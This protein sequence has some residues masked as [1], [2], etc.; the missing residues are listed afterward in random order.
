[1]QALDDPSLGGKAALVL[2]DDAA[3]PD[4]APPVSVTERLAFACDLSASREWR[5]VVLD[6]AKGT[7]ASVAPLDDD[8]LRALAATAAA[9][10]V[11]SLRALI[12]A[13]E[14]ARGLA[15]LA[16]R[17]AASKAAHRR[18]ATGARAAR[19]AIAATGRRRSAARRHPAPAPRW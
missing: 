9:L 18:S 7:L 10:G 19:N 16:G 5:G 13:G 4:E 14:A 1:M 15:A 3:E 11:D 12:F 2:L 8:T 6:A 17:D